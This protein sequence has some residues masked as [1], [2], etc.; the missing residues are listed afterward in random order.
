MLARGPQPG[1]VALTSGPCPVW[2]WERYESDVPLGF[3]LLHHDLQ[4][5]LTR[6]GKEPATAAAELL[7][8]APELLARWGHDPVQADLVCRA[9]LITL[10]DRYLADDQEGAGARLGVVQNWILPVLSGTAS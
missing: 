8:A 3:D 6:Q 1:N 5:A 7:R 2:D 4:D 9:Y 10:A